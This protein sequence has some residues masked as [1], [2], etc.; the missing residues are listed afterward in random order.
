MKAKRILPL[1]LSLALLA[2]TGCSAPAGEDTDTP[3]PPLSTD[4]EG[5]STATDLDIVID[6]GE[7]LT[8]WQTPKYQ[9]V[10][11]FY[12]IPL[13]GLTCLDQSG[14]PVSIDQLSWDQL[15]TLTFTGDLPQPDYENV[16]DIQPRYTYSLPAGQVLYLTIQEGEA[17][18]VV[19][20][21][22]GLTANQLTEVAVQADNFDPPSFTP[23]ASPV[24]EEAVELLTSIRATLQPNPNLEPL[25]GGPSTLRL[26]YADGTQLLVGINDGANFQLTLQT[27]AGTE[28]Y[29]ARNIYLDGLSEIISTAL[30]Y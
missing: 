4:G 12:A 13:D 24:L 20:P 3:Q 18:Q 1:L 17:Q 10:E 26:T 11:F 2:F 29:R 30:G 9:E 28:Y 5:I 16:A 14:N 22:A 6:D 7:I 21:F 19:Q 23:L 27:Q 8:L 25:N 15:V